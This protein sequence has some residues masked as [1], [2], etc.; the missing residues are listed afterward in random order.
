[1]SYTVDTDFQSYY[2]NT[3]DVNIID[4]ENDAFFDDADYTEDF[5][6]IDYL[7]Y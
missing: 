4:D 3:R 5:E 2:M 6:P 1:M 7:N